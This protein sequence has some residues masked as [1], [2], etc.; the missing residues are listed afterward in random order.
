MTT[1]SKER[2]YVFWRYD[3]FPF[4]L[5]SP[6]TKEADETSTLHESSAPNAVYVPKYQGWVRPI[7][8]TTPDEGEVIRNELEVLRERYAAAQ[9]QL[10]E[11]YR[12]KALEVAPWLGNLVSYGGTGKL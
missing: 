1:Y 5:G 7:H 9:R 12:A 8:A 11:E 2:S 4:V 3:L 6:A 10:L